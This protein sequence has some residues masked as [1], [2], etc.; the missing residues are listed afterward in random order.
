[1]PLPAHH[2][3]RRAF[4]TSIAAVGALAIPG[5]M[6][7][8]IESS[9]PLY[10]IRNSVLGRYADAHEVASHDHQMVTRDRQYNASQSWRLVPLGNGVFEILQWSTRRYVDA[11]EDAG[12]DWQMVTRPFQDH[13]TQH[14]ILDSVGTNTWTIR[15]RA[16]DRYVDAHE[17]AGHDWRMVLRPF[18]NHPTQHWVI[19]RA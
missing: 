11:H 9:L 5:K 18:Q 19:T 16:L 14:W 13:P 3:T 6:V 10:T 2:L 7:A 12:H 4:I 8:Q 1:M 17:D 15:N